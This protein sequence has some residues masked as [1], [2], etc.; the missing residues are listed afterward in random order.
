M[1]EAAQHDQVDEAAIP[2]LLSQVTATDTGGSERGWLK[3][4]RHP[5]RTMQRVDAPDGPQRT[6]VTKVPAK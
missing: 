1:L 2:A 6:R 3:P 4:S 5:P